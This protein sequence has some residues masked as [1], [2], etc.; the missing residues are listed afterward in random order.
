M[1]GVEWPTLT[2][3]ES[4]G[5][6]KH[7]LILDWDA[8]SDQ[9]ESPYCQKRGCSILRAL[10]WIKII[11]FTIFHAFAIVQG[12]LFRLGK[13]TL[14]ELRKRIYRSLLCGWPIRYFS[15]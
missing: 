4:A 2:R 8:R 3:H 1:L 15:G 13:V 10:L 5:Q 6:Q 7:A 9:A 12:K 11:A 14:Q